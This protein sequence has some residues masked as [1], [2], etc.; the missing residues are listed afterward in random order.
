[1][2]KLKTIMDILKVLFLLGFISSGLLILALPQKQ[3]LWFITIYL[4]Y[5]FISSIMFS[6]AVENNIEKKEIIKGIMKIL[7]GAFVIYLIYYNVFKLLSILDLMNKAQGGNT[8]IN[9]TS[10]FFYLIGLRK[11]TEN[12]L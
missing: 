11:K 2:I 5:F 4:L 12:S 8:S 7:L 10:A 9:V 6:H 1:M 3:L